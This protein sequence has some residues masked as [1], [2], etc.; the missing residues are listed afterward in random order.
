[1]ANLTNR[2]CFII[3]N[4]SEFTPRSLKVNYESLATDDSGRTADGIMHV[5]YI[6]SRIRKLQI[7]MPPM[8]PQE[9]H[10]LLSLVQGQTY[11]IKY[12]DPLADAVKEIEVYTSGSSADCY[13]G[14]LNSNGLWQ[15][16]S[17]NAIELGGE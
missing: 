4:A 7:E 9:V 2:G 15:G 3:N 5:D 8:T 12:Y 14:V 17:F 13:S 1:M 6:F 11:S 16:V 10:R